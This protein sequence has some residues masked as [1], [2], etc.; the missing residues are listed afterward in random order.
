MPKIRCDYRVLNS[1]RN[2]PP[3]KVCDKP[4]V[5]FFLARSK[6]MPQQ[7][8]TACDYHAPVRLGG[9]GFGYDEVTWEEYLVALVM[10]A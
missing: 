2:Y 4:A 7:V 9:G 1:F 8:A 5:R 6:E 3:I 10:D